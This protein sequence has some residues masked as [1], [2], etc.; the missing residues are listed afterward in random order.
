MDDVF[1][2]QINSSYEILHKIRLLPNM[3]VDVFV[4]L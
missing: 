3:V 4:R 1:L 2:I